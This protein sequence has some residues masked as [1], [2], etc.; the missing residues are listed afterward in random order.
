MSDIR[1][2]GNT[3]PAAGVVYDMSRRRVQSA[4]PEPGPASDT[5]AVTEGAR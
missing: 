3:T 4:E 1:K 5:S 2:T